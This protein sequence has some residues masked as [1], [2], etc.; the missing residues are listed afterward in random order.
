MGLRIDVIT[1][2]P[3]VFEP[4]LSASMIGIAR[5]R[6]LVE[7]RMVNL[8]DFTEDRHRKVDDRPYGGGPGMVFKPEPVFNAVEDAVSGDPRSRVILLTPEGRTFKQAD[9][10]DLARE[11]HIV[12]VC[13]HY[14]G[15]DERIRIGLKPDEIS[16]GDFVL[17]GG[18]GAAI[19]VVDAVVRLLPG[20]LGSAESNVRESFEGGLLDHP[21][22]TRPEEYRG[23]RVPEVLLSGDHAK[24]EEWRREQ[25]RL[26]TSERRADLIE[27]GSQK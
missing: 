25:A 17:T 21:H 2:F 3:E 4:F 14:E 26:R 9:A 13:G 22:Y 27:K 12:L 16:I 15:F 6:G 8:R 23:M 11:S 7:F 20:A 24:I 19:V 10:R 5:S 18:E 1:I